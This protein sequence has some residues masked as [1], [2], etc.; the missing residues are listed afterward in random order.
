MTNKS[1]GTGVGMGIHRTNIK[2][3]FGWLWHSWMEA[4]HE[5]PILR[6]VALAALATAGAA[7]YLAFSEGGTRLQLVGYVATAVL[8]ALEIPVIFYLLFEVYRKHRTDAIFDSKRLAD[9][10]RKLALEQIEARE[11]ARNAVKKTFLIMAHEDEDVLLGEG[12]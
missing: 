7:V 6:W 9:L 12:S 3:V 11:D 10:I 4:Q 5:V 1:M 8:Y 2:K